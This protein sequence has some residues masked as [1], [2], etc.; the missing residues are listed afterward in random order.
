VRYSSLAFGGYVS[1]SLC[2]E[3]PGVS[4]GVYSE[5]KSCSTRPS[6]TPS[7]SLAGNV[8]LSWRT[9]LGISSRSI[10]RLYVFWAGDIKSFASCQSDPAEADIDT[11][12]VCFFRECVKALQ[13]NGLLQHGEVLETGALTI[14]LSG[15][16]VYII[17][18]GSLFTNGWI[19]RQKDLYNQ[20]RL[21]NQKAKWTRALSPQWMYPFSRLST[22]RKIRSNERKETPALPPFHVVRL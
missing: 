10:N 1:G 14:R 13:G 22:L 6:D 4:Q 16:S 15:H 20:T 3:E 8:R 17:H 19:D 2:G 12:G 5:P 18:I 11:D 9:A 7:D 21:F